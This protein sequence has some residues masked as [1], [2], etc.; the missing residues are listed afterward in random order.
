[1]KSLF[2][3]QEL[4]AAGCYALQF[5]INGVPKVVVV[6]DHFPTK[7]NKAGDVALAFAKSSKGEN[8][9]WMLLVE[10]AYAKIC[11]SYEA[12]EKDISGPNEGEVCQTKDFTPT[13]DEALDKK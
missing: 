4:N 2:L 12:M 11:G 9:I 3:T 10:K 1:M 6:D 13:G 8:E 5:R 7:I